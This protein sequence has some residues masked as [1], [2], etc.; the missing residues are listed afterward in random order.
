MNDEMVESMCYAPRGLGRIGKLAEEFDSRRLEWDEFCDHLRKEC[1][2]CL[3][4]SPG[5][6]AK[7][8]LQA[9]LRMAKR[10]EDAEE[11]RL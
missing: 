1:A 7:L 9:L 4:L 8:K 6:A 10:V 2:E 5:E 3:G 11:G